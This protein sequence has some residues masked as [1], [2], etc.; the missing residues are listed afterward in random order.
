MY[1][2]S[3]APAKYSGVRG[4]G[5]LEMTT[6]TGELTRSARR[7]LDTSRS[8]EAATIGDV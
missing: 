7:S 8:A 3:R 4:P 5:T 2:S 1:A 6:F